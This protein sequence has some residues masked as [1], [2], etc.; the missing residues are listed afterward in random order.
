MVNLVQ[1]DLYKLRKTK[2]I[3][4]LFAITTV[5]AAV[6]TMLAYLIPQGKIEDS[7]AQIGFMFSDVNVISILGAVVA[8]I[9]ICGD[10]DNKIIHNAIANGSGRGA[11]IVSKTAV[12]CFAI[13]LILLPYAVITG[14]ARG[15]GS[16]FGM[17][18]M[19]IGFLNLL[20]SESGTALSTAEVWKLLAVMLTLLIV[21]M[22][23]LSICV[24]L[25]L[26]LKKPVFVIAIYYAFTIACGQL[27]GLKE[28]YPTFYR[29]FSFTP[30]GGDYSFMNL[31]T[32]SE[33]LL[34]AVGVSLAF[35]IVMLA[36]AYS[37]FRKSEI[38]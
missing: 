16:E 23:Q 30:Y 9:F 34:Q 37:T 3:K 5:C 27:T 7:M 2:S 15:S 22:A 29:I 6:M 8:G 20:T 13:A 32:E 38:K 17:G 21:Y 28:S 1:A 36:I 25:A 4:I 12:F 19:S 18:S 33:D 26:M 10:F 31:H 24:P 14:I 11:V 35:I